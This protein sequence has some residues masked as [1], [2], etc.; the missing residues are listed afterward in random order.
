VQPVLN[1]GLRR[2]NTSTIGQLT[3]TNNGTQPLVVSSVTSSGAPFITPT[4]GTCTAPVEPGR[5]CRVAV[6]FRPTAAGT[7]TGTLT[8]G[9]NATNSPTLVA[10]TGVAR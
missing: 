6:T 9:S 3:V 1:F 7:F 10:L 4:R 8:I 5:N 2:L